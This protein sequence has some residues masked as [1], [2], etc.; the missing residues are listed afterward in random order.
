MCVGPWKVEEVGAHSSDSF[1][2]PLFSST[3]SSRHVSVGEMNRGQM[4]LCVWWERRAVLSGNPLWGHQAPQHP[5]ILALAQLGST[6]K[7]PGLATAGVLWL[8]LGGGATL[9]S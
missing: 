3:C 2:G 1:A 7:L 8:T 5:P 6:R 4:R 9:G